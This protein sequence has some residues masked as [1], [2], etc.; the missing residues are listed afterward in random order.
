M[1]FSQ[2]SR[3]TTYTIVYKLPPFD[4]LFYLDIFTI[5]QLVIILLVPILFGSIKS[6]LT[7]EKNSQENSFRF[8]NH[9]FF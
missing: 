3:S 6:L 4:P 1:E 5:Y 8:Y 9:Y 2:P 7:S